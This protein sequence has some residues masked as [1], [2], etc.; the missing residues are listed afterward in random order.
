MSKWWIILLLVA[1]TDVS[2]RVDILYEHTVLMQDYDNTLA[3]EHLTH[4][5]DT[6]QKISEL[7]QCFN[8]SV[9]GTRNQK[10]IMLEN[11]MSQIMEQ[12]YE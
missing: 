7:A 2:H 6:D 12:F 10:V 9:K 8:M 1:C 4:P 3:Y 11:T 5:N